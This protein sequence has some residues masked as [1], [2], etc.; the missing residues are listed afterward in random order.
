[1]I[2]QDA[3]RIKTP[4]P[5][6]PSRRVSAS[7]S[8]VRVARRAARQMSCSRWCPREEIWLGRSGARAAR[9]RDDRQ[10]ARLTVPSASE[11]DRAAR[12][13]CCE[14]R[15]SDGRACRRQGRAA[16]ANSQPAFAK[17]MSSALVLCAVA[18][19]RRARRTEALLQIR[20]KDGCAIV[21]RADAA[22]RRLAR[23]GSGATKSQL[24]R[25]RLAMSSTARRRDPE[26][27]VEI[28]RAGSCAAHPLAEPQTGGTN[29]P[30]AVPEPAKSRG[31]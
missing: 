3:A 8:G 2:G 10:L 11:R 13:C 30:P 1:M 25:S 21:S 31:D 4:A 29:A 7:P 5:P 24:A 9:P 20:R 23:V 16:G 27:V 17:K 22:C 12:A 26:I 19:A 28:F 14:K 6:P 15:R 18:W